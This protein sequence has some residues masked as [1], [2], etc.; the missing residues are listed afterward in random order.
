MKRKS[1][2]QRDMVLAYIKSFG[3]HVT[4]EE[5]YKN[6]KDAGQDISLA[7]VYRNLNILVEMEEIKRVVHPTEGYLYDPTCEP[8]YHLHCINCNRLIDL[9]MPFMDSLNSIIQAQTGIQVCT[10]S[11]TVDGSCN[12]CSQSNIR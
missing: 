7:T 6:M 1:S 3:E 12:D 9:D 2:K 10:H 5:V 4:A 11:L 8:H